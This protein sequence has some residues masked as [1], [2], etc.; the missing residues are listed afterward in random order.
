MEAWTR[1]PLARFSADG[2]TWQYAAYDQ[3]IKKAVRAVGARN[4]LVEQYML[5]LLRELEH[6]GI[7]T[8]ILKGCHLFGT[9]YPFGVRPVGDIDIMIDRRHFAAADAVVR[10]LGGYA[11]RAKDLDLWSHLNIANKVTYTTAAAPALVPIDMHFA[12]GPYPYLGRFPFAQ[13]LMYSEPAPLPNLS[14]VLVLQPE[15]LLVH[16]C[17]H[18]FQH[19]D[20]HREVSAHDIRALT[21][22]LAAKIDWRRFLAITTAHAVHLPVR[23][24]LGIAA[25]IA[26]AQIPAAVL[27]ELAALPSTRGQRRI[28]QISLGAAQEFDRHVVQFLTLPGIRAKLLCLKR[29]VLPGQ[30]FLKTYYKGSYLKYIKGILAV[31]CRGLFRLLRQPVRSSARRQCARS[32]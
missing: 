6:K 26:G 23:H 1:A 27:A 29:I 13:L 2:C 12:L 17:L 11:H 22:L 18:V 16:L 9:I 14:S 5:L 25:A 15:M 19:H 30:G 8:I 21:T 3:D 24:S 4:M 20:F 10:Q 31:A 28:F 7:P 32:E